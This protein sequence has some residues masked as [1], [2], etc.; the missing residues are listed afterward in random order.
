MGPRAVQPLGSGR[1]QQKEGW[2]RKVVLGQ[3]WPVWALYRTGAVPFD[4]ELATGQ[5]PPPYEFDAAAHAGRKD[6]SVPRLD[7][8]VGLAAEQTD[9]AFVVLLNRFASRTRVTVLP[10]SCL[11][12]CEGHLACGSPFLSHV[13]ASIVVQFCIISRTEQRVRRRGL[14]ARLPRLE[15]DFLFWFDIR[16]RSPCRF[17]QASQVEWSFVRRSHAIHA[18]SIC[19]VLLRRP[20]SGYRRLSLVR[21][22]EQKGNGSLFMPGLDRG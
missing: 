20:I 9:S 21:R 13:E 10:K 12:G 1:L 22:G 3:Q 14:S 16:Q 5:L 7:S 17:G 4:K 2:A 11:P 18:D 8:A 6:R 15:T 19:P